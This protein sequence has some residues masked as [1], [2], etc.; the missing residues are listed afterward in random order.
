MEL[1]FGSPLP[2]A[3]AWPI[4]GAE[5]RSRQ[6]ILVVEVALRASRPGIPYC[7]GRA[8]FLAGNDYL[9]AFNSGIR[10]VKLSVRAGKDRK[11]TRLNSS[12]GYISYAVF[13]L[14]K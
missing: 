13:C 6:A 3:C 11:S 7:N 1:R 2:C 9:V 4:V 12:H 14:K 10:P 8:H 5:R